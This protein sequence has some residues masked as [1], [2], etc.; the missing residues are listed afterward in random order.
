LQKPDAHGAPIS[1]QI[2]PTAEIPRLFPEPIRFHIGFF[3]AL[4]VAFL[5]YWL[6]FKTSW[7]FDLRQLER[8]QAQLAMQGSTLC[9]TSFWR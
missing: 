8:I 5:V 1:P 6:L 7:G 2:L 9:G 4:A 3:I